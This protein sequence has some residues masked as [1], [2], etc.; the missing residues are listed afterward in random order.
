MKIPIKGPHA[1]VPTWEQRRKFLHNFC[2]A[3]IKSLRKE[4]SEITEVV[5]GG[6]FG[7]FNNLARSLSSVLLKHYNSS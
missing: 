2:F 4:M 7:I 1:S 5:K 6:R 3:E